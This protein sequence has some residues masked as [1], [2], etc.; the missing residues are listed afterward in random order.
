MR[1]DKIIVPAPKTIKSLKKKERE[2]IFG[3]GGLVFG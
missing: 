2:V 3:N 1:G